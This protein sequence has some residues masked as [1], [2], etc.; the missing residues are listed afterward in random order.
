MTYAVPGYWENGYGELEQ[1]TL[2]ATNNVGSSLS[3][4]VNTA[5][6]SLLVTGNVSVTNSELLQQLLVSSYLLSSTSSNANSSQSSSISVSIS[7]IG[8]SNSTSS[9]S[10]DVNNSYPQNIS[11]TYSLQFSYL[12]TDLKVTGTSKLY[13]SSPYSNYSSIDYTIPG[14]TGT[15]Y[16][17]DS[18]QYN[19]SSSAIVGIDLSNMPIILTSIVNYSYSQV[20][21]VNITS[22]Q[23]ILGTNN[24]SYSYTTT[25]NLVQNQ[26][27]T[28]TDN[29]S[30]SISNSHEINSSQILYGANIVQYSISSNGRVNL[31]HNIE[32]QPLISYNFSLTNNIEQNI[33][34]QYYPL[35]SINE[36]TTGKI[37]SIS[38]L[39]GFSLIQRS[40]SLGSSIF[41]GYSNVHN[42]V[43]SS[44]YTN[45]DTFGYLYPDYVGVDYRGDSGQVN[46]V[47]DSRVVLYST[48]SIA[49][50]YQSNY[51]STDIIYLTQYINYNNV[52]N[53]NYSSSDII[54]VDQNTYAN[55]HIQFNA[56][57]VAN[58]LSDQILYTDPLI[59][60]NT[61][62]ENKVYAV[63][64]IL[65]NNVQQINSVPNVNVWLD[66]FIEGLPTYQSAISALAFIY[67]EHNILNT[68][69][70]NTSISSTGKISAVH[71]IVDIFDN[72]TVNI[73]PV[74]VSREQNLEFNSYNNQFGTVFIEYEEG[75]IQ[76]SRLRIMYTNYVSS[77]A[78]AATNSSSLSIY[79]VASETISKVWRSTGTN[80]II[81]LSWA[82]GKDIDGIIL[83]NTNLSNTATISLEAYADTA[84]TIP[85]V[86]STNQLAMPGTTAQ[87]R[88]IEN[89]YSS[90]KTARAWISAKNVKCLKIN[91][92]DINNVDGYIELSNLMAGPVWSPRYGVDGTV[93]LKFTDTSNILKTTN[94]N[95]L[96][97]TGILY[98]EISMSMG[99]LT[100]RDKDRLFDIIKLAGTKYPIYVTMYPDDPNG[101]KEQMYQ[102]YGKITNSATLTNPMYRMYANDLTV[103]EVH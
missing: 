52:I 31:L 39:S 102:V 27:T 62:S 51:S 81:T 68:F 58:V 85:M 76:R 97:N 59:Q 41:V 20:Q 33:N 64:Y 30:Y 61:S 78:L 103:E 82:S 77:A 71:N 2:T 87:T 67:Q 16:S 65:Y 80:T 8:G 38:A 12:Q 47:S 92:D 26:Y 69:N 3:E 99:H 95:K 1:I 7:L 49:N 37:T 56:S 88:Y 6:N 50:S 4:S 57:N 74:R 86:N 54:H 9:T 90:G 66:T 14:Y 32:S 84:G 28:S 93:D 89:S 98:K 15:D 45:Y 70:I 73:P 48:V 34:I 79:N 19:T 21:S 63:Q 75:L 10:A 5:F 101:N 100:E 22:L 83:H 40:N 96:L 55:N 44:Q 25:A 13:G 72:I 60:F 18:A 24:Y 42:L 35:V 43:G 11:S 23:A 94:G 91:I 46:T 17:G 53:Y 36:T 29:I